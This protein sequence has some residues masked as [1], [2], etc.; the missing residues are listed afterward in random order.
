M[1]CEYK[2]LLFSKLPWCEEKQLV[3]CEVIRVRRK[4][5]VCEVPHPLL[6]SETFARLGPVSWTPQF[7]L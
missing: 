7:F 2:G 5:F 3:K 4:C 1:C 6:V